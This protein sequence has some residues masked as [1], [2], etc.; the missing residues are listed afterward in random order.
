MLAV[1]LLV[2][3]SWAQA[4]NLATFDLDCTPTTGASFRLRFDLAKQKWCGSDCRSVLPI[5]DLSDQA[6][7]LTYKTVPQ[8]QYWTILINRYTSDMFITR[9][10]YGDKP[11]NGGHC[12]AKP[13]SGFP[14]KRF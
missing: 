5:T 10:G 14:E 4:A 9:H 13:F 8:D 12:I 11:Q 7:K 3:G 6:I 1:A 2:S